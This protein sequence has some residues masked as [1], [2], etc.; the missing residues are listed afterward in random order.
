MEPIAKLLEFVQDVKAPRLER[1]ES[2]THCDPEECNRSIPWTE[3]VLSKGVVPESGQC[4][5]SIANSPST[6]QAFRNGAPKL[7]KVSLSASSM[8]ATFVDFSNVTN[9]TLCSRDYLI[10][11]DDLEFI[12]RQFD[13]L[14]TL[15]LDGFM[16]EEWLETRHFD[17]TD[18]PA[19]LLNHLKDLKLSAKSYDIY[20]NDPLPLLCTPNLQRLTFDDFWPES[21]DVLRID[22]KERNLYPNLTELTLGVVG[23]VNIIPPSPH[24]IPF[25]TDTTRYQI[26]RFDLDLGDTSEDLW[27]HF[28]KRAIQNACVCFPHIEKLVIHERLLS[29]LVA[30]LIPVQGVDSEGNR[31]THD[32]WIAWPQLRQLTVKA[33][34][35][36]WVIRSEVKELLRK[37][38]QYG[39]PIPVVKTDYK[40][41]GSCW[42]VDDLMEETERLRL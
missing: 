6:I 8:A 29:D 4:G 39:V 26:G 41:R 12:L 40:A 23:Q 30:A 35:P 42:E 25:I 28:W 20:A 24:N 2:D 33:V 10:H 27:I 5:F 9:L 22:S 34:V 13:R 19:L 37:R 14:Q 15:H 16:C 11:C 36:H 21:L 3:D 31:N 1:F 7:T 38:K 17:T 18:P 32:T